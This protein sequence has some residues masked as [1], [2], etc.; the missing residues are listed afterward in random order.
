[1]E[2]D[3]LTSKSPFTSL[4]VFSVPVIM[5]N[6]FQQLYTMVDSAIVGRYVSQNALAAVGAS[7]SITN[8]FICVAIGGGIGAGVIVSRYFG[9]KKSAKLK[10]A[11]FTS[12]FAFLALSLILSAVGL[13]V[14]QP[15]MEALKTPSDSLNDASVYLNIYFLG[16][17]F[18]F[19]YNIFSSLF[20]AFGK[21]KIPL[22]FLLFSSIL[23]VV[24]DLIFVKEFK[25]GVA[26]AA[27]A[28]LLSQGISAVFSFIVF[29]AVLKKITVEME[30]SLC[31]Q[32]DAKSEHKV[33]LFSFPELNSMT[34]TAVPSILQ[35]STVSIGMML[36]QSVVN[37]FGSECLAGYTA[38]ARIAAVCIVPVASLNNSVS[39]YTAQNIGAGKI[40][41]VVKGYHCANIL[42]VFFA[43]FIAF[44]IHFA[45]SPLIDFFLGDDKTPL[46]VQT[47]KNFIR[48]EGSFYCWIG[49]KM[50]VDG[51]LRGAGDMKMFT[52]AN[53][54][55]LSI[56]VVLSMVLAPRYGIGWVWY[57]VPIGW[58][59][60]FVISF[61]R[62]KTGKWKSAAVLA[63]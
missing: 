7:F 25:M 36:V 20:N 62:Y 4:L 45:Y 17:P 13:F 24:L 22:C 15:L 40:D 43:A 1:M 14:S 2:Q 19:M 26:G 63:K 61:A 31:L 42:V 60:N 47:G 35:Q 56:R 33:R 28:T 3:Y 6:F 29:L 16:L 38:A 46:A 32:N 9:A 53:L 37:S 48:F 12:L 30:K 55:N 58:F 41:R 44:A 50:A 8:I 18:L 59:A 10:T 51:V 23:N 52:V 21:S 34:K 57:S 27:W 49:F 54:V 5:G 39:S 11:C